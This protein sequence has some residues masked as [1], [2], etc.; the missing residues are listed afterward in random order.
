MAS[1]SWVLAISG[2]ISCA[3]ALVFYLLFLS[4]T[5]PEYW[6]QDIDTLL[7]ANCEIVSILPVP[8]LEDT[9][10]TFVCVLPFGGSPNLDNIMFLL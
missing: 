1:P 3:V 9:D 2:L 10:K 7:W 6:V 8:S 4:V 5:K